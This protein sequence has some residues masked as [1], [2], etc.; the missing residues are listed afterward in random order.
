MPERMAKLDGQAAFA[1]LATTKKR[2][3]SAA[4]AREIEEGSTL[5]VAIRAALATMESKG[6]YMD[7]EAFEKEAEALVGLLAVL[8]Q[9]AAAGAGTS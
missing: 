1:N 5:Q 8:R 6:R 2:K 3:N 7:R 4:A 9:V